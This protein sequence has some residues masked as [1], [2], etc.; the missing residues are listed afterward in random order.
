MKFSIVTPTFNSEKYIRETIES[1][2]SQKGDFS[3]EYIVLDNHSTDS[4]QDIV[5]EYQQ[6]LAAGKIAIFCQAVQ[7]HLI[8]ERDSGMYDAIKKGFSEAHGDVFAWINSDDIYLS[9]AFDIIKKSLDKYPEISW[10]KGITS[11]INENSTIY[12]VGDCNLYRQDWIK[13]G[14]YGTALYFIQQDSVFWRV[15]LWRESGGVD[16]NLSMAGDYFLWKSFAE[17]TPLYSLNAYVS[18]FRKTPNQ[19]SLDMHAYWQE[20]DKNLSPDK[21][22]SDKVRRYFLGMKFVPYFLRP[23]CYRL[24]FGQYKHQ[25]VTLENG[26]D[27]LLWKGDYFALKDKV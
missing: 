1:V 24:V 6:L 12:S 19:K 7:L 10:I 3:I 18:C 14:L 16:K 22:L 9:G 8:S 4:T 27:P 17:L 13:A 2:V 23:L 21:Y 5:K 11:Y 25:L 20:I 26:T 15:D